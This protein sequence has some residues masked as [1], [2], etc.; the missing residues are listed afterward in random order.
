MRDQGRLTKKQV[1]T[2]PGRFWPTEWSSM[3]QN[4]QHKATYKC[5]E[6]KSKLDAAREQCDIH[7]VPDDD[8]DS[9]HETAQAAS[10]L[11]QVIG[12]RWNRKDRTLLHMQGKIVRT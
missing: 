12:V 4:S 3:S 2:R 1:S 7:S 9:Q 8:P 11:V 10:D 6:E 5:A